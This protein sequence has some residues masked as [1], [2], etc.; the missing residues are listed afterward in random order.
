MKKNA[1][2]TL[3]YVF[4][5][6][7]LIG[8]SEEH[9]SEKISEIE[10]QIENELKSKCSSNLKSEILAKTNPEAYK[11]RRESIEKHIKS[12]I[13]DKKLKEANGQKTEETVVEIPI[14][15]HSFWTKLKH[16][17]TTQ[18]AE[19]Q[20][21]VLNE[22]FGMTNPGLINIPMEF[23]NAVSEDT[24]I[25]FRLKKLVHI[26]VTAEQWRSFGQNGNRMKNVDEGGASAIRPRR[27]LNIWVGKQDGGFSS[28][29]W[30]DT[31]DEN[32]I[33][34][35]GVVVGYDSFGIN[36]IDRGRLMTHE[37]GHYLGL[38]HIW[39]GNDTSGLR[40]NCDIDDE[41]AD[42]PNTKGQNLGDC[43]VNETCQSNDMIM[44]F[45]DYTD[46][47]CQYM[48]TEGQKSRMRAH[49]AEGGARSRLGNLGTN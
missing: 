7:V 5:L 15:I 3:F 37:V 14:I 36:T 2:I 6:I 23:E 8:C 30:D 28:F 18:Q 42:T 19:D 38:L 26:K 22:D 41:V 44:N 4:N 10:D 45:M 25:Q 24:N 9:P 48:F 34:L 27:N 49:F 1:L 11:A 29:P 40:T 43:F 47:R 20:I 12:F 16:K 17:V 46:G 31:E 33:V 35:D 39:G 32:G 21:D 13:V